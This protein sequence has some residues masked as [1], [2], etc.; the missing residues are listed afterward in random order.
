MTSSSRRC[1]YLLGWL[2]LLPLA[3][4]ADLGAAR[5][6]IDSAGL[7]MGARHLVAQQALYAVHDLQTADGSRLRQYVGADGRVFAVRWDT[8]YKP[9]LARLLG[10]AFAGYA[11][12]AQ[13]AAQ[14]GGIRRQFRHEE[15]DLVVQAS[16]HLHVYSGYAYRRSLLPPGLNPLSLGL[17]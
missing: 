9:D 4:R 10:S 5:S 17:G 7:R 6:S 3:A 8:L 11:R 1:L 16:G 15:A 12:A 13:A 14:Q 2:L